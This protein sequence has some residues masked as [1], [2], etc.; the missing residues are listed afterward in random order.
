MSTWLPGYDRWK[1]S[2]PDEGED[3]DADNNECEECGERFKSPVDHR[4]NCVETICR[5]CDTRINACTC[6]DC[7]ECN[8]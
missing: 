3:P 7:D 4:G 5:E 6:G 8:A 2:L 1:T